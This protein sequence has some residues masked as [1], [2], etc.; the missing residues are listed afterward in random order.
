MSPRAKWLAVTALY[1]GI[2]LVY[3]RTLL[4]VIGSGLPNDP[5]DPGLNT[6]ILWWNAQ[7]LPLTEAW[8]NAPI[9]F[10]VKGTLALSETFL[11]LWPLSTPMQWA[12]ASAVLTYNVMFLLSFPTA[13]LAAHLLA[14]RLTG[15][16]DA[17]LVAGLAFGFAP[18]RGAQIAHLQ[19]QW[20]C[21]MPL[22]LYALHRFVD[23]RRRR[24]LV[25][26]AVC[27]VMN[28][29]STGYYLLFFAVLAGFW[30]VWFARSVRDWVAIGAATLVANLALAPWLLGYRHHQ[31]AFGVTRNIEEI[32]FFS[33]DLI[34]LLMTHATVLSNRWTLEAWPERELYPGAAV[35]VLIALGFVAA[36]WR[37]WPERRSRIQ[38]WLMG[39]AAA[40]SAAA[41]FAWRS[42]GAIVEVVG[43][44]LSMTRPVRVAQIA[45][46]LILVSLCWEPRLREAWRRRSPFLFYSLAA[47]LM[48][49]FALGPD[50]RLNGTQLLPTAPYAWLMELPGGRSVRVPARFAML[51]ALCLAAAAA[52]AFR[53]LTPRG[54]SPVLTSAIALAVTLEGFAPRMPVV[55]APPPLNV[56]GLGRGTT[57]LELPAHDEY[58]D[59]AAMVHATQNGAGLVNGFSG[60]W[61]PHYHPF[62]ESL[63]HIN[64]SGIE[65]LREF[66]TLHVYVERE[67]DRNDRY[68]DLV[69]G[70][71]GVERIMLNQQGTLFRLPRHVP[72]VL[73][74]APAQ[75]AEI[76][77]NNQPAQAFSMTDGRLDTIWQTPI[78]QSKGDEVTITL[79]RP[80]VISRLEMDLGVAFFD[81]PRWLR[82][83]VVGDGPA[84]TVVWEGATMGSA[85]RAALTDHARM[86]MVI[87]VASKVLGQK[88][89]LT[90]LEDHAT[91][92]WSIAEVRVFGLK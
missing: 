40:A 12:G 53:R 15:R 91:F 65:V 38:P 33:G 2:T 89:V 86:P 26:F 62:K 17:G 42:G 76:A 74:L 10:P 64:A 60:Y 46:A 44:R 30:T 81:Y 39:L 50:V 83:S 4:P 43:M 79:D 1:V 6:W 25:L 3:A 78:H 70:L 18:Y 22:A 36:W 41:V 68:R 61:P 31:S 63:S 72:E 54:S 20:S 27:W 48:L 69:A 35:V 51:F 37:V 87:D 32:R 67:A 49:L 21:W 52:L 82:I 29:L 90:L 14:W 23:G 92:P 16:H 71:P 56:A 66:G 34:A 77:T 45:A 9:F 84:P 55:P 85:V 73:E 59:S 11:N 19:A 88:V 8:W 75:I 5:I 57:L 47:V 13:A 7:V 80:T 24:D 58:D 28:G